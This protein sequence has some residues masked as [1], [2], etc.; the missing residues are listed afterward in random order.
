MITSVSTTKGGDLEVDDPNG[1]STSSISIKTIIIISIVRFNNMNIS[2][3]D[4]CI[5]WRLVTLVLSRE[6]FNKY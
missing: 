4:D 2:I 6:L 5:D 1:I 3:T